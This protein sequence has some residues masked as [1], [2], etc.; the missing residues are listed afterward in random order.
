MLCC[1]VLFSLI[2]VPQ[3]ALAGYPQEKP[4]LEVLKGQAPS[5]TSF[6]YQGELK[7]ANGPANGSYDLRFTLYS[8]QTG[9]QELGSVIHE[10]Q[11]L[12]N[13]LFSVQLNF[14]VFILDAP[15]GWVEIAV[16]PSGS[17]K[18]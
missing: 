4:N 18:E 1:V 8:A 5:H 6:T 15:E 13:G 7:D 14:G 10:D 11:V 12:I 17:T 16:R 3:I 9:G 2:A